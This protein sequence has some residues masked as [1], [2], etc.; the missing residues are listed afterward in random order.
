MTDDELIQRAREAWD[1]LAWGDAKAAGIAAI[2]ALFRALDE[3]DAL[4]KR[5]AELEQSETFYK[6]RCDALQDEQSKFR[7][8]ERQ[9]VC[10]ILANGRRDPVIEGLRR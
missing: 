3:R 4:R 8:P 2:P 5:V 7:D 1:R 10:D 9:I 6:R